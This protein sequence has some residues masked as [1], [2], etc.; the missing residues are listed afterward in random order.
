MSVRIGNIGFHVAFAVPNEGKDR[1]E[2]FLKTHESF[3]RETHHL[4]GTTEP[5]V[6]TYAVLR[7]PEFH[8]P[9]DPSSGET[10]RTLYG[11]IELYN[12]PEGAQAHME[13]GM[14]REQM[15]AELVAL[16]G[17]YCVSGILGAPVIHAM[18]DN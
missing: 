2:K 15:F 8:N 16:T 17:E 4:S 10:G 1:I 12:G 5:V 11:L 13:A 9:L 14:A 6:L 7:S 18:K 3:M